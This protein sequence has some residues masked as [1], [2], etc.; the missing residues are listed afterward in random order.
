MPIHARRAREGQNSVKLYEFLQVLRRR[1]CTVTAVALLGLTVGV[2][3]TWAAEPEYEATNRLFAAP[4]GAETMGER[5]QYSSF[6]T[7]RV[8]SYAEI[9]ASPRFTE[10]VVKKLKLKETPVQLA[11]RISAEAPPQS[12]LLDITA[13]DGT[14]AGAARIAN[15]VATEFRRQMT[16]LETPVSRLTEEER[17]K[18]AEA[19]RARGE[20]PPLEGPQPDPL[21]RLEVI[22][23]AQVPDEPASPRPLLNA[24]CALAIGLFC[25]ALL[26]VVRDGSDTTV[27]DTQQLAKA[28]G[29]APVLGTVPY[30]RR[31]QRHPLAMVSDAH[32]ER[33]E[34]VR[35][36]RAALQFTQVDRPACTILV[37]SADAEEGKSAF[38]VNLALA[39]AQSGSRVCLVDADLRQPRVARFFGLVENAGLTTALIGRATLDDVLQHIDGGRVAVLASGELPPNPAELLASARMREVLAELAGRFD[40]IIIDSAPL[41]PV[42]DSTGLAAHTD[43]TVLVVRA[44]HTPRHRIED[45]V[46]ALRVVGASMLGA[47]LSM[48]RLPKEDRYG[49]YGNANSGR[50]QGPSL[51]DTSLTG[52]LR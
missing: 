42:A 37:T 32:G 19:A 2:T 47:V 36:V 22:S 25:G 38:A 15:A 18:Q 48:A 23:A 11:E 10:P 46:A 1:W 6:A 49:H 17:E 9:V 40:K 39:F 31:A 24:L 16:L 7:Q 44:K 12:V 20:K 41:L 5:A 21:T 8:R 34:A 3:L 30:D 43:G 52:S 26:A 28:A 45:A 27:S 50:A 33:A 4:Q 51:R 35:L 29:G 13:R 14:A